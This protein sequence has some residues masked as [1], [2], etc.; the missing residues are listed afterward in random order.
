[1]FFSYITSIL[2]FSF[3]LYGIWHV[4]LDLWDFYHSCRTANPIRASLLVIVQNNEQI[5]EGIF[6]SL[7]RELAANSCWRDFVIVDYASEDLT[8]IILDRL[9]Q[10]YPQVQVLYLSALAKPVSEGI[11]LCQGEVIYVI[12]LV[13]RV[14]S[15]QF[16]AAVDVIKRL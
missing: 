13:S 7:L 16:T 3:A 12:D 1:M 9:V 11:A 6:R 15:E 8:P 2:L 14:P 5:I 10:N 4:L